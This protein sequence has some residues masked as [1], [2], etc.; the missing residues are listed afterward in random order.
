MVETKFQKKFKYMGF[1]FP[2][3]LLNVPM[4]KIRGIWTP[5]INYN[6]LGDKVYLLLNNKKSKLTNEQARFIKHYQINK[7]L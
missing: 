6:A 7:E 1:G 2:I 4:I 5:N 3:V